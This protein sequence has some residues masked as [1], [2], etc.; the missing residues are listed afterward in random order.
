MPFTVAGRAPGSSLRRRFRKSEKR[1]RNSS[2][3]LVLSFRDTQ[4][5][6][7]RTSTRQAERAAPPLR[8]R[9]LQRIPARNKGWLDCPG[10]PLPERLAPPGFL[11]LL[12]P[13]SAPCLLAIFQTRSA[14]GVSPSELC[15]SRAAVHRLRRRY[16]HDVGTPL[17]KRHRPRAPPRNR[18]SKTEASDL[19]RDTANGDLAYRVLLHTRVRHRKPTV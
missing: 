9:P 16:P 17:H 6:S 1:I 7:S 8:F 15:S 5:S 2:H 4:A 13:C 18:S 12:T 14:H 19:K 3:G 11:N 10:M